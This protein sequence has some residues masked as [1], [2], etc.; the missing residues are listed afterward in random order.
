L[1]G[2]NKDDRDNNAF[3]SVVDS[4]HRMHRGALTR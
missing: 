4:S 3:T 1:V 2:H